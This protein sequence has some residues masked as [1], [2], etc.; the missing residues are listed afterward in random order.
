MKP[1]LVAR[2]PEPPLTEGCSWV[3][4]LTTAGLARAAACTMAESSE[5]VTPDRRL[6]DW[7]FVRDCSWSTPSAT[8]PATS[9]AR[10]TTADMYMTG[11]Q[12]PRLAGTPSALAAVA[13]SGASRPATS[14]LTLRV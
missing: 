4:T 12:G 8:A 14:D 10:T 13:S 7:G 3:T 2:Y 9:A 5:I 1:S 6:T 11:L